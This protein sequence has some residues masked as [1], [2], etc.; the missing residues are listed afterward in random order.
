MR[1]EPLYKDPRFKRLNVTQGLSQSTVNALLIDR[2]GFLWVA[3]EWGLN[4][5]DGHQVRLVTEGNVLDRTAIYELFE[6]S[7]GLI[8]VSTLWDGIFVLD[9]DSGDIRA[10]ISEKSGYLDN[11]SQSA[12]FIT[13]G[14]D[15][16]IWLALDE[17]VVAYNKQTAELTTYFSLDQDQIKAQ[18]S[19]RALVHYKNSLFVATTL[20]LYVVDMDSLKSRQVHY[21][22]PEQRSMDAVNT[23]VFEFGDDGE[24]YIGTVEG[25]Y[26]LTPEQVE[27]LSQGKD[28][29]AQA[30][31]PSINTWAMV[32]RKHLYY[33]ATDLGL[34]SYD[35]NTDQSIHLLN[36][37]LSIYHI[38]SDQLYDLTLDREGNLWLGSDT[39]GALYWQVRPELFTNMT[40]QS[41]GLSNDVVWGQWQE[42]PETL[43][44]GTDNGLNRVDLVSGK[45]KSFLVN[46]D[47]KAVRSSSSIYQ[48]LDAGEEKLWVNHGEGTGLFD[49]LSGE[50]RSLEALAVNP[51]MLE[52]GE[53]WGIH[54]TA[55]GKLWFVH[56][57]GYF[58]YDP[59][60]RQL[61]PIDDLNRSALLPEMSWGFIGQLPGDTTGV[62]MS[63]TYSLWYY[64]FET[65][66]V[67]ELHN[68]RREKAQRYVYA[69]SWALD[70]NGLLWVSY[71][72]VGLVALDA[73]TYQ[74]KFFYKRHQGLP[75]NE[76]Y[77]L[78]F[79]A[80]GALWMSSI[81]GILKLDTKTHHVR[82]YTLMH[83][84][85][86][87]E[88]AEFAGVRLSDGRFSYG[89]YKGITLFEPNVVSQSAITNPG[90]VISGINLMSREL[91]LPYRDLNG[92]TIKLNHDD[93]GLAVDFSALSFSEQENVTYTYRL[94]GAKEVE[95]PPS[96]ESRATFAS[97][98]PGSYTLTV[99]AL[100]AET[101]EKGQ[102]A[103]VFIN[104][105]YPPFASPRAIF[106]YG[107]FVLVAVGCF[108]RRRVAH[109][110]QILRAHQATEQSEK[111]MQLA[112]RGSDSGIWEWESRSEVL[113]QDRPSRVLGYEH[114]PVLNILQ[115][116][117]LV[118]TADQT[119]FVNAW[120][121]YTKG[122]RKSLDITYR[123][124]HKEGYYL[125]FRDIG[126]GI[127]SDGE[128]RL[129][130]TYTNVTD[131][132]ATR[133]R[134]SLFGRIFEHSHEW[135]LVL[136][137]DFRVMDANPAMRKVLAC[138]DDQE[139]QAKV[140]A[141]FAQNPSS[142]ALILEKLNTLKQGQQWNGETKITTLAG[143][144]YVVEADIYAVTEDNGI[145]EGNQFAVTFSDI[146]AQK[147]A[148]AQLQKMASF[149]SLT[150]LPNRMLL[151]D[152]LSH[153]IDQ[154]ER[155]EKS[156]AVMFL[157]LDR[158]KYVNDSLGHEAGDSLLK[159]VAARISASLRKVDTVAR[160]GGDE[161]V[162]LIED[163]GAEAVSQ[164]AEQLV[165][166]IEQPIVI[167]D[168]PVSI[169]TSIGI[170]IYPGDGAN[171]ADLL[172]HSDIAM[173]HAKQAGRGV[174]KFFQEQMNQQVQDRL[175]FAN[176]LKD[177]VARQKFIP[178]YQPI[179]KCSTSQ[180]VAFEVLMRWP[181]ESGFI[182]PD[183]FI[184]KAEELGLVAAMTRDLLQQA[185]ADLYRWRKAG[186]M[187]E[188]SVNLS[189]RHFDEDGLVGEL[190]ELMYQ[191]NLPTNILSLEITEGA[192]MADHQQAKEMMSGL[193]EAGFKLALDDFGTGYSSLRYL[194]EFP[195]EIL[196]IDR[197]FVSEIGKSANAEEIINATLRLAETLHMRCVAEGI[198]EPH[199][200][201]FFKQ[202]G[203]QFLQGYY[204]SK[205]LPADA[206]S[207]YLADVVSANDKQA[208]VLN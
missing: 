201:E 153:A 103:K 131:I 7:E 62:L 23:K 195:I 179:V 125:W 151:L 196:K 60:T 172:K 119:R 27:Q 37:E 176:A 16:R 138:S 140:N 15:G 24:L 114:A 154:A 130:G 93:V 148:T 17:K 199:Q 129:L 128:V 34:F 136:E 185:L 186:Y 141:L 145:S 12:E 177:A 166:A 19:V 173:Y 165:A 108:W 29:V 171:A 45:V 71:P 86:T 10:E 207:T 144:R 85:A 123:L 83:G 158:F 107:A 106:A 109:R 133:E 150:G 44:V 135:V 99:W 182:S 159:V 184:P 50:L 194:Q 127:A 192:L 39:D 193:N 41:A 21:L 53:H 161:F 30:A 54:V 8:W 90:V 94:S 52:G 175:Q 77:S 46:P 115:F 190:S 122:A 208:Q 204:F 104:V 162:V 31:I 117:E 42:N 105:A 197:S 55:E 97:L 43:W 205:P 170:A 189:A 64:D 63:G 132:Y 174:V 89:G 137:Q 142:K 5:Y 40:H 95:Y 156:L 9:P 91:A 98:S 2:S 101:G 72:G 88:F 25:L 152:R 167:S 18:H 147:Q 116:S 102:P 56:E 4:R 69:E 47:D 14:P 70:D 143:E 160:L 58:S 80:G 146:T 38:S 57:Q 188:L 183:R 169:S 113:I 118:H 191:F 22:E 155:A 200:A 79:Q 49:K 3:T 92:S 78:H 6:D 126:S 11:P 111:R 120:T 13:E 198:E 121:R 84:L 112:L 75:S 164:V 181:T 206:A 35:P 48:I 59:T 124:R 96:A 134:A 203:C 51:E 157:D 149:D 68:I 178:Y 20:G 67:K 36:P 168:Q 74:E 139:L 87:E 73:E 32:R 33:L 61:S 163:A 65:G 100:S 187:V 28:I 66:E 180:V 82:R 76:V 110:R 26:R 1:A 81:K 202:R